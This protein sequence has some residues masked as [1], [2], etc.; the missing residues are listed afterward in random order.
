MGIGLDAPAVGR[1]G[2]PDW[3]ARHLAVAPR[4]GDKTTGAV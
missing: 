4:R 3:A 2:V 1:G